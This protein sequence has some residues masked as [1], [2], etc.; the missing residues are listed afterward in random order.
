MMDGL[1]LDRVVRKAS[2]KRSHLNKDVSEVRRPTMRKSMEEYS[3]Q[4]KVSAKALNKNKLGM[5]EEEQGGPFGWRKM[6][7]RKCHER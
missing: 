5:V 6:N 1:L 2:W 7:E 4:A 3:R